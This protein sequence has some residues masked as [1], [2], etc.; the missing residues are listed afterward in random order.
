MYVENSFYNNTLFFSN[1]FDFF[2]Y[3]FISHWRCRAIIKWSV[4][5]FEPFGPNILT[6]KTF[7]FTCPS[8]SLTFEEVSV[9]DSAVFATAVDCSLDFFF[10]GLSFFCFHHC[11]RVYGVIFQN[12]LN[13]KVLSDSFSL[14]GHLEDT[15]NIFSNFKPISIF[16]WKEFE[17]T[18]YRNLLCV[19]LLNKNHI[20]MRP[21]DS[22]CTFV[23][24]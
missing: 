18:V 21:W 17:R 5:I 8:S 3:F 4:T 16:S 20:F 24:L 6:G 9:V 11:V 15:E 1:Q 14:N 7:K 2:S 23:F 19:R 10:Q 12:H 22:S 13:H